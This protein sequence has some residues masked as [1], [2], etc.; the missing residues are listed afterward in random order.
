M[1]Y[2]VKIHKVLTKKDKEADSTYQKRANDFFQADYKATMEK[3][4][5]SGRRGHSTRRGIRRC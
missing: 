4:K 1:N 5:N 3:R 2:T